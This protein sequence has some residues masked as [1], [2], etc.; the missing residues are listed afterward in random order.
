M[1][2][3]S[4]G[5][6]INAV[7]TSPARGTRERFQKDAYACLPCLWSGVPSHRQ[8]SLN[9]FLLLPLGTPGVHPRTEP[10]PPPFAH[11]S[12]V[13]L[14]FPQF[15]GA[16]SHPGLCSGSSLNLE[17]SFPCSESLSSSG[18]SSVLPCDI[19]CVV[20]VRCFSDADP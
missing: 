17:H 15:S 5:L 11:H 10:S 3:T 8:S 7:A 1:S 18:I 20:L 4:Q 9:L 12:A 14:G 19:P 16:F 13:T 6:Y 2:F